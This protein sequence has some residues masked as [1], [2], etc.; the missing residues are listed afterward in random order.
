M[1]RKGERW[2]PQTREKYMAAIRDRDYLGSKN[3]HW[4][5]GRV[6]LGGGRVAVYAPNHPR[7]NLFSGHILEYR[8]IAEQKLGRLLTADEVV[9]HI[10]GDVRDNRPENLE[11][12]TQA[13]H[14]RLHAV[15]R[16][17][18]V[19]GRFLKGRAHG[20]HA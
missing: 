2:S 15:G 19:T 9:H 14:A 4:R 13:E 1:P 7:A 17:D 20:H 3:P 18:P 12:M 16:R 8:L 10:N 5:G 6:Q 11:V